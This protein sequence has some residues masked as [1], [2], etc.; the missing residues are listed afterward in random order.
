VAIRFSVE[1]R[2][3]PLAAAARRLGLGETDFRCRL[4]DLLARGFPPPDLTTGNFD[5][6]AIDAWMDRRSGLG[7]STLPLARDAREVVASRIAEMSR[8]E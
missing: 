7:P 1:P 5:L 2:D 8:H 4:P 3:V 6:K